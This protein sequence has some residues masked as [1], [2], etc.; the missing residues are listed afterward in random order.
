[1]TQTQRDNMFLAVG[2]PKSGTTFLQRLLDMHPEVSCPSE[3]QI[4]MLRAALDEVFD[5]YQEVLQRVDDSTGGQGVPKL[6]LGTRSR[7]FRDIVLRLSID[8]ARGKPIHGLNDNEPFQDIPRY[9]A[10]FNHPKMI[11]I[12]RN[13]VDIALSAWRHS[14]RLARIQPEK[15][16]MHMSVLQNP[17]GSLEGFVEKVVQAYRTLASKAVDYASERD[18]IVVVRYE[19]LVADTALELTRILSFLGADTDP[20]IIQEMV[21]ASSKDAMAKASKSPG[22]FGIGKDAE[23]PV[24][25]PEDFRQAMLDR[26]LTPQMEKIGYSRD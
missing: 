26:W 9:D 21:K 2:S 8:F 5:A 16:K 23:P 1:M 6:T 18:H 12:L 15:A 19:A 22:F 17:K 24:R 7:A 10:Q 11:V 13:P 4:R 14:H 25:L 20:A 3:Q